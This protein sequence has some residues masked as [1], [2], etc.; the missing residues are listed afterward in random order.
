MA[1]RGGKTARGKSKTRTSR[2][3]AEKAQGAALTDPVAD[4]GPLTAESAHPPASA[5]AKAALGGISMSSADAAESITPQPLAKERAQPLPTQ[6]ATSSSP[7]SATQAAPAVAPQAAPSPVAAPQVASAP[8]AA[9]TSPALS[10][11]GVNTGT[12]ARKTLE[13][14]AHCLQGT[15]HGLNR[16]TTSVTVARVVGL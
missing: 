13:Q 1:R 12:P 9:N 6:P 14:R 16:L 3:S 11:I 8:S 10:G 4:E 2:A 5:A 15:R 7:S